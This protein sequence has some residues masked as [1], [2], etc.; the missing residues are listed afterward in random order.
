MNDYDRCPYGRGPA[1]H[2][3]S[4]GDYYPFPAFLM[5]VATALFIMSLM[6]LILAVT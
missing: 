5:G 4:F 3:G 2:P 1:E 6:F